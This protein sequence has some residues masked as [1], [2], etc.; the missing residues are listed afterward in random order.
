M[1]SA[2]LLVYLGGYT[3][4]GNDFT[5]TVSLEG[6][7][8]NYPDVEQ[9]LSLLRETDKAVE[10]LLTY[11]SKIEDDVVIVFFGDHQPSLGDSFYREIEGSSAD[12]LDAQQNRYKVPF[13]IWAN[14]DMEET[15]VECTSLNYLSSYVYQAAGIPLPPYNRFLLEMEYV[16][17][18]INGNGF[19]STRLQCYLPF[20]MA[21]EAE[22]EWLLAYEMLQYNN[23]F[24]RHDRSEVLFVAAEEKE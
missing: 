1:S 18:S 20:D 7:E 21:S 2:A 8:N 13:F 16:I 9:Y 11:F 19:Y 23:L 4:T 14:Y 6:Y 17:P 3:Y 12:S 15:Y 22:K 10:Y 5:E 24:D